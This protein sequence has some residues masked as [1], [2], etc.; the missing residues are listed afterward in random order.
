MKSHYR[1]AGLIS[2]ML[3]MPAAVIAI[4]QAAPANSLQTAE[5]P[6]AVAETAAPAAPSGAPVTGIPG[7][8]GLVRATPS[9]T[10]PIGDSDT[11]WQI[12]PSQVAYFERIERE[13]SHL[14]ARGDVFPVGD[15]DTEWR[16]MPAQAAYFAERERIAAAR[17]AQ[18]ANAVQAE[19]SPAATTGNPL[20]T[21]ADYITGLFK[22]DSASAP[23]EVTAAK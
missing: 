23:A 19:A 11:E 17:P 20:R 1:I 5:P 4:E 10:F 13:R 12:L 18:P 22:S 16:M 15:S 9:S 8:F 6:A 3:A 2:L 21:T 7:W 14:V